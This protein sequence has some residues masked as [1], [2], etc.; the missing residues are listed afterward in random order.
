MEKLVGFRVGYEGGLGWLFE[1]WG[2]VQVRWGEGGHCM[3]W[4]PG[5]LSS[6]IRC[7]CLVSWWQG[8]READYVLDGYD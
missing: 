1:I 8:L 5:K 2:V 7:I 6:W 4:V 3:G